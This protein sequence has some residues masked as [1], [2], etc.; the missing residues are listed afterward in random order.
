M[1]L[2]K[3]KKIKI[4]WPNVH[5]AVKVTISNKTRMKF[6]NRVK[7]KASL[8]FITLVI[9]FSLQQSEKKQPPMLFCCSIVKNISAYRKLAKCKTNSIKELDKKKSNDQNMQQFIRKALIINY[10]T[11]AFC[12]CLW[13]VGC[14]KTKYIKIWQ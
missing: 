6:I 9:F 8:F 11:S 1:W 14:F 4:R 13:Y 3:E 2:E 7:V 12:C 10:S 5:H